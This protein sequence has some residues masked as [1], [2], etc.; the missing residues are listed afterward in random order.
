[1][2]AAMKLAA[3]QH[4]SLLRGNHESST[5]TQLYG[6]RT[7]LFRK[8]GTEVSITAPHST[9]P[10][11]LWGVCTFD[12]PVS[13]LLSSSKR[14]SDARVECCFLG[15]DEA[16]QYE[17][18]LVTLSRGQAID[19][20]LYLQQSLLWSDGFTGGIVTLQVPVQAQQVYKMCKQ[21][22]AALPLAAVVGGAALVVHG[23]LFRRPAQRSGQRT[24]G[25]HAPPKKRKRYA[26]M[27]LANATPILGSL[28]ASH[29][30]NVA[31][32]TAI[33]K[34]PAGK[35]PL[36]EAACMHPLPTTGSWQC[37]AQQMTR[38]SQRSLRSMLPRAWS[39]QLPSWV[40]WWRTTSHS[41]H[42]GFEPHVL[43]LQPCR[44]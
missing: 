21:L 40:V 20:A 41:T 3:P 30:R 12:R 33:F 5:C 22:F 42:I 9:P 43:H 19:R 17:Q 16:S 11:L 8:Y 32:L 44:I 25:S 4:V 29:S 35:L 23:G 18:P 38:R 31:L 15:L 37:I 1:M 14:S 28:E 26:P 6:F 34:L 7:E 36:L 13:P 27:R 2:L 24:A 10:P 39:M